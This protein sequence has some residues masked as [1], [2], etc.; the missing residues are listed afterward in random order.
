MEI[1]DIF[2]DEKIEPSKRITYPIVVDSDDVIVWLP[3]LR[4]SKF[5]I[6]K[7][8]KYDI[9]LKYTKREENTDEKK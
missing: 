5:D 2:I 4:K 6:N 1:K 8:G 9:I 7:D 3:G